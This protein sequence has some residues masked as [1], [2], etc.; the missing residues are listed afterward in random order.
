MASVTV[1]VTVIIVVV[2]VNFPSP[3]LETVVDT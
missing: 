2:V 3:Q 1:A